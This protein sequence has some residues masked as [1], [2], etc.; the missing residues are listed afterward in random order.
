[1]ALSGEKLW[2]L[3]K[4]I[5]SRT[6]ASR[7]SG[8]GSGGCAAQSATKIARSTGGNTPAKRRTWSAVS[9]RRARG[10]AELEL[11]GARR[12]REL[13]ERYFDRDLEITTHAA[14]AA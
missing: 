4:A 13:F 14:D 2:S 11:W 10:D 3:R 12:K 1:M 7:S 5:T 6:R 8:N 9:R